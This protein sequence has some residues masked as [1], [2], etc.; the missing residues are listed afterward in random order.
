MVLPLQ[1]EIKAII[2]QSD[3]EMVI[4]PLIILRQLEQMAP[5]RN[6]AVI[7]GRAVPWE[8]LR[9]AQGTLARWAS[10]A[11]ALKCAP[12]T[13]S[14]ELSPAPL[15]KEEELDR[16]PVKTGSFPDVLPGCF[17]PKGAGD[18]GR[19]GLAGPM[20]CLHTYRSV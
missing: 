4:K 12:V 1:P 8:A 15:L 2:R 13:W 10:S 5:C 16:L 7:L 3:S 20:R 14:E 9:E 11:G 17:S 6:G 19:R 18:R